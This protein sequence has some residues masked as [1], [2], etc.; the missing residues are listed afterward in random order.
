MKILIKNILLS[1]LIITISWILL[2]I[3]FNRI[4]YD[5]SNIMKYSISVV[6]GIGVSELV[7]RFSK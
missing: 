6:L 5:P 4:G 2:I 1:V 3:L 7:S